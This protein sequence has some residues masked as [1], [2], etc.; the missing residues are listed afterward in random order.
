MPPIL[1]PEMWISIIKEISQPCS[2][3][4][5]RLDANCRIALSQLCL[6]SR[7]FNKLTEPL[8]YQRVFITP[9]NLRS[10]A[11]AVV[12]LVG[13]SVNPQGYTPTD[14]GKRVRSLALAQ[15][16]EPP[17]VS[18]MQH[19]GTILYAV[20][21]SVTHLYFDVILRDVDLNSPLHDDVLFSIHNALRGLQNIEEFCSTTS[22]LMW[23]LAPAWEG[24]KRLAVSNVVLSRP[25]IEGLARLKALEICIITVAG[26]FENS[27]FQGPNV[28]IHGDWMRRGMELVLTV[29]GI[30]DLVFRALLR[31]PSCLE[32]EKRSDSGKG[33]LTVMQTAGVAVI[34]S[35]RGYYYDLASWFSREVLDGSIWEGD[36]EEW[37]AYLKREDPR[38]LITPMTL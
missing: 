36:R 15:F 25:I 7:A 20:R 1:P 31:D 27:L 4:A 17:T 21:D 14:R 28:L 9:E 33:V 24:L 5:Y 18:Q 12:M 19:I 3:S 10:F 11:E 38:S 22:Q 26:S 32:L 6:V 29:V 30:H 37:R 2:A 34:N 13:E 35:S 23:R 8:L 16:R